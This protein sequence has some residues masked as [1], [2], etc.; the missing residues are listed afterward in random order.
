VTLTVKNEIPL[1]S[2]SSMQVTIL[3]GYLRYCLY[4]GG[5]LSTGN[6]AVFTACAL[7]AEGAVTVG[8]SNTIDGLIDARHDK[9]TVNRRA[10]VAG[11][12]TAW[13]DVQLQDSSTVN[14]AVQSG[15]K[16][17]LRKLSTVSGDL[18]A[19]RGV[20]IDSTAKVAGTVNASAPAPTFA[21]LTSLV[22]ALTAGSQDVS[23]AKNAGRALAPGSYGALE[24]QDGAT[25][26][27]IAGPYS[28]KSLRLHKGAKIVVN[29]G[30]VSAS[31]LIVD[32]I[33]DVKFED[34]AAVQVTNGGAAQVLFR[35][36]GKRVQISPYG[37]YGGTYLAP[38]ADFQV[39]KNVT[40]KGMLYGAK[41]SA[42]QSVRVTGQ[43]A[44]DPIRSLLAA[45][46]LGR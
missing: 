22:L 8:D 40:V 12:L 4:S 45:G 36:Q 25:L 34:S 7:G 16:A 41:L 44:I 39:Q 13:G 26:N 37:T 43:T 27:L 17:T 28:F 23:V 15:G 30:N 35:I 32:V 9:A 10:T 1:Q 42:D 33:G 38:N 2:T 5:S 6:N 24:L 20:S 3:P 31:S 18:F 14:A 19:S 11:R 46:S 21:R 29:L